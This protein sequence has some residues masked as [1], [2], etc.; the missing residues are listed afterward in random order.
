MYQS[1]RKPAEPK[2]MWMPINS[3]SAYR[4]RP[5]IREG[6]KLEQTIHNSVFQFDDILFSLFGL[7]G[8]KTTE[9]DILG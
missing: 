3:G 8:Q 5:Y 1:T 2:N 4:L 7:S 9:K 6:V